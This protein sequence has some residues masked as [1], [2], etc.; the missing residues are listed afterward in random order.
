LIQSDFD[1]IR[2]VFSTHL[3]IEQKI[4]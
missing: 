2:C 4:S 3:D 1:R